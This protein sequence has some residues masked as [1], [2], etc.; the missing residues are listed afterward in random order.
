MKIK[1]NCAIFFGGRSYWKAENLQINSDFFMPSRALQG[2]RVSMA[3]LIGNRFSASRR[4][5]KEN[6]RLF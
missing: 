2:I 3:E 1:L 6:H 4:K 5:V